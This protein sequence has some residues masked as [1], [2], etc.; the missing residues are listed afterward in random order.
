MPP[1]GT[2]TKAIWAV[3]IVGL[4]LASALGALAVGRMSANKMV[5][6]GPQIRVEKSGQ[7]AST[8]PQSSTNLPVLAQLPR[9]LRLTDHNSQAFSLASFA[10]KAT[11]VNFMFTA[12]PMVCPL[13]TRTMQGLE[14]DLSKLPEW[15][16]TQLLSISVDP[17]TDTPAKLEKYAQSYKIVGPHWLFVTGQ[18]E[19]IIAVIRDGF[20]MSIAADGQSASPIIH[21]EQFALVDGLGNVRGY[22]NPQETLGRATLLRDVASLASF[23]RQATAQ[24]V[25][26]PAGAL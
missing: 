15:S 2:S 12:C 3:F 25:P 9:A 5:Q 22:Y 10:G 16:A 23:Y 24:A 11:V 19:D 7:P 4:L 18:R 20:K 14:K 21:S 13:I 1:Q 8:S 17:A 26:A 6:T